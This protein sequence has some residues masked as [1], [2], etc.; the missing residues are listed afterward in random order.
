MPGLFQRARAACESLL[1]AWSAV[2]ATEALLLMSSDRFD[3]ARLV[4]QEALQ[5][6]GEPL[7]LWSAYALVEVVRGADE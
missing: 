3:E 6:H 5:Q 2:V 7:L 4:L 1:P